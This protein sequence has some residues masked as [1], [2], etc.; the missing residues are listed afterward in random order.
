MH[1]FNQ[2]SSQQIRRKFKR[3]E[4]ADKVLYDRCGGH[5]RDTSGVQNEG[6]LPQFC[7][8]FYEF[9]DFCA[10]NP[11]A[12]QDNQQQMNVRVTNSVIGHQPALTSEV[13]GQLDLLS[14]VA[15]GG[16]QRGS[17]AIAGSVD[18]EIVNVSG[19]DTR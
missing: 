17:G 1:R 2:C 9:F 12:P 16:Q 19:N 11:G 14:S 3:A 18:M 5:Q 15:P 8:L 7:N 10:T 6:Q 13:D 4:N